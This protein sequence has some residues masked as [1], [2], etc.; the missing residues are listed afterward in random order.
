M[1]AHKPRH[2]RSAKVAPVGVAKTWH[3]LLTAQSGHSVSPVS[4]HAFAPPQA[5]TKTVLCATL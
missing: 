3:D 2:R 1:K 5:K 4:E